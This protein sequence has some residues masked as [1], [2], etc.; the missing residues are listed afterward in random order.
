MLGIRLFVSFLGA[1]SAY[2]FWCQCKLLV[3]G[4][5]R[6]Q[7]T[8]D[9]NSRNLGLSPNFKLPKLALL[10]LGISDAGPHDF[11]PRNSHRKFRDQVLQKTDLGRKQRSI[12]FQSLTQIQ[13][14][15]LQNPWKF[16]SISNKNLKHFCG[17]LTKGKCSSS[18]RKVI[19]LQLYC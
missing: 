2:F 9:K 6:V 3:S 12:F 7:P 14:S 15:H 11:K 5:G 4:R 16:Q 8:S 18:S 17:R 1:S 13:C 19:I 10:E